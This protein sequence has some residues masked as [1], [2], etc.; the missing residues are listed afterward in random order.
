M[1]S[2]ANKAYTR[3]CEQGF[4]CTRSAHQRL[5][6]RVEVICA[7]RINGIYTCMPRIGLWLTSTRLGVP[8]CVHNSAQ[9][10]LTIDPLNGLMQRLANILH[11][12]RGVLSTILN[13]FK[14][15]IPPGGYVPPNSSNG[16]RIQPFFLADAGFSNS[17]AKC[18]HSLKWT[19][20]KKS[21][22]MISLHG[23]WFTHRSASDLFLSKNIA[24]PHNLH[25]EP[26]CRL[27]YRILQVVGK[28]GIRVRWAYRYIIPP[29]LSILYNQYYECPTKFLT[30]Q[31]MSLFQYSL[32]EVFCDQM[33]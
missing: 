14:A 7:V 33:H 16:C 4:P 25:A 29:K 23:S 8:W 21:S 27:Q 5:N 26:G 22:H 3:G 20:T 18:Q 17:Y 1:S 13:L 6:T 11:Y 2:C 10:I 32:F 15:A 9:G 30:C 19:Q 24:S 12:T 28:E 31:L